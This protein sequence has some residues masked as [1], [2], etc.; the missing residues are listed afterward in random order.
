MASSLRSVKREF[1]EYLELERGRSLNTI[2][3]Y[4]RYLARFLAFAKVDAPDNITD[5]LVRSFRLWLSRQK[6]TNG[7]RHH[8]L[9]KQTQNY[10]QIALRSFLKYLVKR[11]IR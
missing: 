9:T 7:G 5:D 2:V 4:D 3:H 1:L 10:Y 6:A 8:T 11:G